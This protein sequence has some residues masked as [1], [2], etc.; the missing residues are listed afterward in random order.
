MQLLRKEYRIYE[1]LTTLLVL[2]NSSDLKDC[3]GALDR[4][5]VFMYFQRQERQNIVC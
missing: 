1:Q 3:F 4:I 5:S 2:N